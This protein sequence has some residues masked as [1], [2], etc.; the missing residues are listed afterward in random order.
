MESTCPFETP[1]S[2]SERDRRAMHKLAQRC[3]SETMMDYEHVLASKS[4]LPSATRWKPV[5]KKDN[6]V[7]YQDQLVLEEGQVAGRPHR[8]VSRGGL[9]VS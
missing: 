7:V 4:G 3:I 6:V 8:L 5:K 9:A 2:L 1:L